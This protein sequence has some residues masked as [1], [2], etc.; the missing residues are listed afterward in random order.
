[1]PKVS[2]KRE[3][4]LVTP[5]TMQWSNFIKR[6]MQTATEPTVI[7]FGQP[8]PDTTVDPQLNVRLD[9]RMTQLMTRKWLSKVFYQGVPQ[10]YAY[11]ALSSS[12]TYGN[13]IPIKA[14]KCDS[15]AFYVF[16]SKSSYAEYEFIHVNAEQTTYDVMSNKVPLHCRI[17]ANPSICC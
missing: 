16:N 3:D 6:A 11:D 14:I 7:I 13:M 8:L 10:F 2:T 1:M 15:Y 5:N 4:S 12:P 17:D 9:R